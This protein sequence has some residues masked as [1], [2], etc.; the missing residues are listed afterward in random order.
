MQLA[1]P[2]LAKKVTCPAVLFRV[3]KWN[4]DVEYRDDLRTHLVH[5]TNWDDENEVIT[6]DVSN[7]TF[8]PARPLAYVVQ[9]HRENPDHAIAIVVRISVVEFLEVVEICVTHC[10]HVTSGQPPLHFCLDLDGARQS[11]RG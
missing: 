11:G 6:T 3:L 9:D 8:F 7:K 5:G 4:E 10:E 2:I 1:A